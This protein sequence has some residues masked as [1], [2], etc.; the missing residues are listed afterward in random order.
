MIDWA[1]YRQF[2]KFNSENNRMEA[3]EYLE[4]HQK[5]YGLAG[6]NSDQPSE[7]SLY[8]CKRE[9]TYKE[10]KKKREV[11]LKKGEENK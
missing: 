11:S 3:M 2:M 9:I 1:A 8:Y 10:L 4:E 7:N 6:F 5:S